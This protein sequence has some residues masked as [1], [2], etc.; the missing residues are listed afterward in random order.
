MSY[1]PIDCDYYDRLEAW[2]TQNALL[3]I[4]TKAG[5][6]SQVVEA[7]IVDLWAKDH[8]EYMKLSTGDTIRL[9]AIVAINDGTGR[10]EMPLSSQCSQ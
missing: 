6:A 5:D 1:Q 2:A 4:Y 7:V 8:V 10:Y 9:D 3:T